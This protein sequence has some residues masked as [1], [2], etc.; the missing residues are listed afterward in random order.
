ACRSVCA[1]NY[2]PPWFPG[3]KFQRDA[4]QWKAT[5]LRARDGPHAWAKQQ[6]AAGTARRSMTSHLL[7]AGIDGA[8]LAEEVVAN[9]AGMVYFAMNADTSVETMRAFFLA[10]ALFPE[11]QI[12][13][14]AELDAVC[15]GALPTLQDRFAGDGKKRMPFVEAL[16]NKV[17]RHYPPLSLGVP[18]RLMQDDDY[19]GM[20]LRQNARI[21]PNQYAML[22]DPSTYPNPDVFDPYCVL[23]PDGRL[24]TSEEVM[25]PRVVAFGFGRRICPGRHFVDD[26]EWL[27]IA[28]V[29]YVFDV[30]LP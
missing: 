12:T 15:G 25:D 9:S 21:I 10:H 30:R 27:M 29:L 4:K 19:E 3:A 14:Q 1:V 6:I 11:H 24:K 22:H 2:I 8:P 16:C 23:H 18:H 13:A 5:Q 26:E 20:L 7:E 17:V 28:T